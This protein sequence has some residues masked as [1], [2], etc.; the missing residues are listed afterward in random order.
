MATL[1]NPMQASSMQQPSMGI[2]AS[3]MTAFGSVAAAHRATMD[4]RS[5]ESQTDAQL[6]AQGITRADLSRVLFDRHFR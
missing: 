5:L 2:L 1:T 6:A 4:F 3:I